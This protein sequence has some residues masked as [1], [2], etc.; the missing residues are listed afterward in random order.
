M[1]KKF[2]MTFFLFALIAGSTS[3]L[4]AQ[5]KVTKKVLKIHNSAMAFDT[6]VDTP[7]K[8]LKEGFDVSQRNEAPQSLVDI[9]R[10]QEGG[11]DAIFFAV[12]TPQR[13]RNQVNYDKTYALA[14][15]MIDSINAVTKRYSRNVEFAQSIADAERINS[16]GKISIF[17][18]MENGFPIAKDLSR[19]KEFYNKGVRYVTLS[20]SS[21]NDIC[22][23]STDSNGAEHNGLSAFGKEVVKEMNRLGMVIDISHVSDKAFF[24]VVELSK[25]PMIA[26]HSSVRSV[27]NHPRNMNDEMIKSIAA[28]GGVV[29]ICLLGDYIKDADTTSVNY[30]KMQE[31]KA[32]YNNW[33]YKNEAEQQRAWAEWDSISVNFPPKL[34][35]VADA[36]DH[37]DYIVNLVGVDYVGIGSDFDGGGGLADCKDVADFPK[38]TAELLKRGYSIE[39]IH[40]IWGGNFMRVMREV[41]KLKSI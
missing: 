9:P 10:M 16:E 30:V 40:K 5:A 3:E 37:I 1:K 25:A 29:Q 8:L 13:E 35:T 14:N 34:P 11:L 17:M 26:S 12:F 36:V 15:Q 31:L 24:D 2:V 32:K 38:I 6:H 7:M 4:Y 33:H 21:N 20:H 39:D 19:V 23:S 18:G 28:K 27:C 22:D 41:E